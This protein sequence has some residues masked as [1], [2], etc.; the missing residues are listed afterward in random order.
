MISPIQ[1]TD[2][3]VHEATYEQNPAWE[4][5]G[6]VRTE[7]RVFVRES[8]VYGPDAEAPEPGRVWLDFDVFT[9]LGVLDDEG[10]GASRPVG[11]VEAGAS[12]GAFLRVG[13]NDLDSAA[14]RSP[15]VLAVACSAQV[16][17]LSVPEGGGRDFAPVV[18]A[19]AA[20][21]LYGMAR[22]IALSLTQT[23]SKV[24]LPSLS[25]QRVVERES[26]FESRD[27]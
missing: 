8:L 13:V 26:E 22:H 3:V 7:A 4:Q 23:T 10:D 14:A 17:V 24:I 18:R 20:G 5:D 6:S 21:M 11:E 1:L 19:N 16:V 15:F 9:S 27:E 12:Y 25:F 2:F